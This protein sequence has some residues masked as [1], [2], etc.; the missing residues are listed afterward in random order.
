[1]F[2]EG[3]WSRGWELNPRPADYESAALT[4]SYFG[5]VSTLASRGK[6][7]HVNLQS[8]ICFF[9]FMTLPLPAVQFVSDLFL[10]YQVWQLR[11][12]NTSVDR[13][14]LKN[15]FAVISGE[16]STSEG[17]TSTYENP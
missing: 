12:E 16:H 15:D 17:N 11:L 4:L 5:V 7:A 14:T 9:Q 3:N 1:V 8:L 10:W 13:T 6:S 2:I